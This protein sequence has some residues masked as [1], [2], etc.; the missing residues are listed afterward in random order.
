M[1]D[2]YILDKEKRLVKIGTIGD[3]EAIKKFEEFRREFNKNTKHP[4]FNPR[5]GWDE[6][7]GIQISTVMLPFDHGYDDVRVFETMTNYNGLWTDQERYST[8]E[9]AIKG[10]RRA[11]DKVLAHIKQT[12]GNTENDQSATSINYKREDY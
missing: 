11:V 1:G 8:Y 2:V 5:L 7:K 12:H 3:V 6:I 10:H 9:E 4:S